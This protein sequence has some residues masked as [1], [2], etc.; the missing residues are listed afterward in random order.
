VRCL[1]LYGSEDLRVVDL[2]YTSGFGSSLEDQDAAGDHAG[3]TTC[4]LPGEL[5]DLEDPLF[6]FIIS[7]CPSA[8]TAADR[9][10][11]QPPE[12]L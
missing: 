12:S 11:V 2:P 9:P 5:P 7:R 1:C 4:S 6:R 3:S 10:N 8:G